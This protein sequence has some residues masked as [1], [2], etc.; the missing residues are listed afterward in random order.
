[1]S[2]TVNY[3]FSTEVTPD[4]KLECVFVQ[5]NAIFFSGDSSLQCADYSYILPFPQTL[6]TTHSMHLSQLKSNTMAFDGIE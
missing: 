5:K 1:M 3:C 2:Q 6:F 4:V